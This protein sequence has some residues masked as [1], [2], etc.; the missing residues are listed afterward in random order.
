MYI[1]N[2]QPL[3]RF[4]L[5]MS[6]NVACHIQPRIFQ[7]VIILRFCVMQPWRNPIEVLC[8]ETKRINWDQASFHRGKK[9]WNDDH[10]LALSQIRLRGLIF[11]IPIPKG[12]NKLI[13][14]RKWK[15]WGINANAII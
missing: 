11:F 1:S 2:L 9:C 15:K 13:Y 12:E 7:V 3:S 5:T 14:L 6:Q 4:R 10:V 8:R